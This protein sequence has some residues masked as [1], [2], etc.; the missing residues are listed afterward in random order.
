M[1][2]SPLSFETEKSWKS[3]PLIWK[4]LIMHKISIFLAQSS[5]VNYR[6]ISANSA[7]LITE[8]FFFFF[9]AASSCLNLQERTSSFKTTYLWML[10]VR[11]VFKVNP[12]LLDAHFIAV[13][14]LSS[15][16]FCW[17]LSLSSLFGRREQLL[18]FFL[19]FSLSSGNSGAVDGRLVVTPLPPLL[20][21]GLRAQGG[22][23][24]GSEAH[25]RQEVCLWTRDAKI[26]S[27]TL[28]SAMFVIAL[29]TKHLLRVLLTVEPKVQTYLFLSFACAPKCFGF[30]C[31]FV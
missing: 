3:K 2:L 7:S 31:L 21:P 10:A 14:Y 16:L 6:R 28:S 25:H 8:W 24:R 18:I 15:F 13:D 30:V 9:F 29:T 1:S 12:A 22:C 4:H 20:Q 27:H 23:S 5:R 11:F 17:T 26:H 19:F